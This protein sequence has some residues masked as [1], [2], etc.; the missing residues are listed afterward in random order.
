MIRVLLFVICLLVAAPASADVAFT[1]AERRAVL[2]FGP[3][4]PVMSQDP[5][6]IVSGD[7]TAIQLGERLFQD[8]R[9]SPSATVSCETCHQPKQSFTDGRVVAKGT[10]EGIRNTPSLLNAGLSRWFGWAGDSD[11]LWG[12]SIRPI[13]ASAEMAGGSVHVQA[14]ISGDPAVATAFEQAFGQPVQAMTDEAALVAVGK[15]LAA[16]QETL[17]SS[18]TPFDNFRDALA[19]G[20]KA[21]V[22][23]YPDS[24]KRGLKLFIGEGRCN[25]CHLG[26]A[27][28][29]GEFDD[30]GIPFFTDLG[31]VDKGRYAGIEAFKRSPFTRLGAYSDDPAGADS[32]TA[33]ASRH[34]A[35]QGRAFGSFKVPSLRGV[36]DTAPY[37]HNGS[38]ATLADVIN[39]YSVMDQER[40][41]I[42]GAAIL[43]PLNL[44][45]SQ[46][47]DLEAFLRSLSPEK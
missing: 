6:N 38:L 4:P 34:V 17:V 21:A 43:R 45:S 18:R 39:H 27:F 46:A 28:T 37:M 33:V 3:W 9:L 40:L 19:A 24:A 42:D 11:T 26:S 20:D 2:G 13:V 15:A 1:P 31:K 10:G 14:L 16:Y 12:A 25:L 5:S 29:N 44:T 8:R 32:P 7:P 23:A 41:H 30:V 36:A 35:L 22:A 47:A